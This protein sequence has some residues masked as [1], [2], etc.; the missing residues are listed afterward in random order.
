MMLVYIAM[1]DKSK[2]MKTNTEV[3][4]Q[5]LK[6]MFKNKRKHDVLND[7]NCIVIK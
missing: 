4:S 6:N 2:D 3:D 1:S 5:M 7:K